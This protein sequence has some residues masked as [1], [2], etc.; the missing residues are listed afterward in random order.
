MLLQSFV[1]ATIAPFASHRPEGRCCRRR[2]SDTVSR[3]VRYTDVM[4]YVPLVPLR[5]DNVEDATAGFLA[6]AAER[7]RHLRDS[8][9]PIWDVRFEWR[10]VRGDAEIAAVARE[11]LRRPL[12]AH[13]VERLADYPFWDSCWVPAGRRAMAVPKAPLST[14]A[15]RVMKVPQSDSALSPTRRGASLTEI[16]GLSSPP[17]PG[18]R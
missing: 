9:G 16:K 7:V 15:V 18:L 2:T 14:A 10:P 17:R 8:G 4:R 12:R 6:R 1:N 3:P 13:L 5:R 11:L